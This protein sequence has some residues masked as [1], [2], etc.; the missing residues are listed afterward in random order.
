MPRSQYEYPDD[1]FDRSRMSF[2]DHIDELRVRL[3]RAIKA[4]G[5]CLLLGFALDGI[6]ESL[7]YDNFGVGR[8]M[9]KIIVAPAEAQMRA[10]Y[11]RRT[12]RAIDRLLEAE[13]AAKTYTPDQIA[14]FRAKLQKYDGDSTDLTIEEWVALRGAPVEMPVTV[15]GT[16]LDRALGERYGLTP[17]GDAPAQVSMTLNVVPARLHYLNNKGETLLEIRQFMKTQSA[18]EAFMVYFKVSL[19]CGVI[20]A[21]PIIFYQFWSFIAAGLYPH[22]KKYVHNYLPFSVFLFLTGIALCQFIVLPGAVKALLGFNNFLDLDPDLRLNEWLGFA[23]VLPLVFGVSFQTPLV[24]F[25]LSRIGMFTYKDYWSKWRYALII[26]AGTSALITPT[27][28]AVTMLYLL[29]PLFGLY[30]LGILLCYLFPSTIRDWD[31]DD[32]DESQ[33]AV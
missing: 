9:L 4:L 13:A 22:E 32:E 5:V 29:I 10:F 24:M 18:T 3:I 6:G 16:E 27:P 30:M 2:G 15:A 7:G 17:K 23:I 20:I 25:V 12:E 14:E 31:D 8:P 11:Y 33:I 26:L 28:D 1:I 21:S 19:L